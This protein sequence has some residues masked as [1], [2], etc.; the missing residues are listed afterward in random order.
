M[1][2]DSDLFEPDLEFDSEHSVD[3]TNDNDKATDTVS[4]APLYQE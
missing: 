1:T 4:S 3:A 2:L